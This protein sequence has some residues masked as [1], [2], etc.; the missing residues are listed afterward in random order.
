LR[1]FLS[2]LKMSRGGLIAWSLLILI[3]GLFAVYMFPTVSSSTMDYI[4]Y[5][6]SLPESLRAAMGLGNLDIS[7]LTFTLDTFVA[8]E[9]LMFWP[10]M[11]V[12]YAIFA[13]VNLSREAERGTLDLLLAQPVSRARVLLT[14]SIVMISGVVVVA[15]ASW[16]G[17]VMGLPLIDSTAISLGNQALALMT[18]ALLVLAVGSYTVLFNVIF[19]EPRKALLASGGLTAVM[20]IINFIVPVLSPALSWLRNFSFFYHY[21]AVEIVRTGSIDFTA[22]IVYSSV[23]VGCLAAAYFIF[24]CRNIAA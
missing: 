24:N 12:F 18:G 14:R 13:G 3:Y 17:I 1:L 5:I 9:F 22:V 6:A 4:G 10:L 7:S 8:V 19:L 15:V 11:M 23:L 2:N 16:L 20:Y 21:N